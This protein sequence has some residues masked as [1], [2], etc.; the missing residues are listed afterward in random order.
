MFGLGF[1]FY[2]PRAHFVGRGYWY[3]RDTNFLLDKIF[4][5]SIEFLFLE[6][7]ILLRS[8]ST[9]SDTAALS[10]S[11]FMKLS[12]L[13]MTM[14]ILIQKIIVIF[15]ISFFASFCGT[16]A[17]SEEIEV[18]VYEGPKSCQDEI[19]GAGDKKITKVQ[20][21]CIVG[22]HFTASDDATGRKIE[23]SHDLGVAPSF[24]GKWDTHS[25]QSQYIY[26]TWVTTLARYSQNACP[27]FLM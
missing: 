1:H 9:I 23:S 6:G 11:T 12:S 19:D 21:D 25:L 16:A 20:K 3:H 27:S 15:I 8:Q 13:C 5:G 7:W 17:L 26:Y 2:F 24:P 4:N 14:Q 22:F 10:T 18:I